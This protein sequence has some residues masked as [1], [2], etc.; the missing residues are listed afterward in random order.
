[1]LIDIADVQL[2]VRNYE[3]GV[4]SSYLCARQ[5]GDVLLCAKYESTFDYHSLVHEQLV[6]IAA[7]TGIV[8]FMDIQ[9]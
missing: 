8:M 9:T 3:R 7:G 1:M 6:M 4:M 2:L 5:P